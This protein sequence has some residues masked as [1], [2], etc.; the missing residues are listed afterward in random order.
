MLS[1]SFS[2]TDSRCSSTVVFLSCVHFVCDCRFCTTVLT[3]GWQHVHEFSFMCGLQFWAF[4]SVI[5]RQISV[6][7]F[8][9][10]VKVLHLSLSVTF[11][12]ASSCIQFPIFGELTF[13]GEVQFYLFRFSMNLWLS[14]S[15]R[16]IPLLCTFQLSLYDLI[17]T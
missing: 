9:S 17:L 13:G 6:F 11:R 4:L 5:F 2:F 1:V 8:V 7:I 16:F 10:E 12:F 14:I 3:T 15:K